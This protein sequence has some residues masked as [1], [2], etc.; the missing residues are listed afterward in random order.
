MPTPADPRVLVTN[1]DGIDSPGIE[2]L[3][4]CLSEDFDTV[5]VA[6][7]WDM[8]GS[9]TGIGHF[10]PAKGVALTKVDRS[11]IAAYTVEGPPGLAVLAGMLGAFGPP[12]DLVVSGVNAGMNTGHS[13]IHSGTVGAALTA[14][15]MGAHGLAVSLAQS[16]PWHW[17]SA[18]TVAR[19][20]VDWVLAR[21][22]PKVVLN[23]NVPALP[24]VDLR[25]VR[26][27]DLDAFGH[28]RVAIAD[29]PGEKLEFEVRGSGAGLD[30]ATDT[31]LCL[32]GNVTLTLLSTI[33][34]APFPP[35]EPTAVWNPSE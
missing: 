1:D 22:G 17:D 13:V 6:P 18:V 5:V 16:D 8:S 28:I 35:E 30:Q 4:Q 9:G 20:A 2:R 19:S 25:G 10:D 11:D 33:S 21:R 32:D 14:R 12:P 24:L 27:A 7:V 15:T 34:P 29:V 31:A 23:I 3:A 26:W